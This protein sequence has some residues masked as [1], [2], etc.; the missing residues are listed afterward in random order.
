MQNLVKRAIFAVLGVAVMLGYWTFFGG[1]KGSSST[2][3]IPT[4]VWAG[5]AGTLTIEVET[6]TQSRFSISF[7]DESKPGGEAKSL[8]AWEEIPAGSHSWTIDVPAKVGGTI[9]L[10]AVAPKVG[11]KLSWKIK[12]NGR[13]VDEQSQT[14]DEALKAGYAFGIQFHMDDYSSG[15]TDSDE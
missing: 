11:D 3:K 5:G 6:S 15:T 13:T 12:V 14:L 4:K 7:W 9:D 1:S 10:G 8:E 2:N